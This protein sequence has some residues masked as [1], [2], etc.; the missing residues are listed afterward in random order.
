MLIRSNGFKPQWFSAGIVPNVKNL[1]L[2]TLEVD[3]NLLIN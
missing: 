2:Q 1:I 3:I